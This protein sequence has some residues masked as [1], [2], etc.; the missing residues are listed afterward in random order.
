MPVAHSSFSASRRRPL[1]G[2]GCLQEMYREER[3]AEKNKY[4]EEAAQGRRTRRY[5]VFTTSDVS[6]WIGSWPTPHTSH[7]TPACHRSL[8]ASRRCRIIL[9]IA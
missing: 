7:L 3:R 2:S 4:W 8:L 6:G 9:C 5:M 1:T